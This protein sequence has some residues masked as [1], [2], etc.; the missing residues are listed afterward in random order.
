M[1]SCFVSAEHHYQTCLFSSTKK[2]SFSWKYFSSL[3]ISWIIYRTSAII[4]RSG[5]WRPGIALGVTQ[6]QPA[7][8][9]ITWHAKSQTTKSIPGLYKKLTEYT[10]HHI[11]IPHSILGLCIHPML[12]QHH[13]SG[14]P[15]TRK[16]IYDKYE[17]SSLRGISKIKPKKI[18]LVPEDITYY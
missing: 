5:L 14:P 9:L 11:S 6:R 7:F 10:Y 4:T 2:I 1:V 18:A 3:H 15:N 12:M 13:C 8:K 16:S 17:A